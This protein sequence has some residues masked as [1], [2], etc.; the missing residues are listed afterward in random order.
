MNYMTCYCAT[1]AAAWLLPLIN[2]SSKQFLKGSWDLLVCK[3]LFFVDML[4]L[5]PVMSDKSCDPDGTQTPSLWQR[6]N[7]WTW[8]SLPLR[9]SPAHGLGQGQPPELG[10]HLSNCLLLA[11][12]HIWPL[13]DEI[14]QHRCWPNFH[15]SS[16][17]AAEMIDDAQ[18]LAWMNANILW[19][20]EMFIWNFLILSHLEEWWEVLARYQLNVEKPME[21]IPGVHFL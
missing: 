12:F 1:L 8:S 2:L 17:D 15:N 18:F 6:S 11:F 7:T 9:P 5:D 10:Q 3:Y 20:E 16:P 14:S 4:N 21:Q 13:G 19:P